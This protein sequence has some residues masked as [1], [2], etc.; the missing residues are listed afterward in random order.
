MA[1]HRRK[2]RGDSYTDGR[3]DETAKHEGGQ[4]R[5]TKRTADTGTE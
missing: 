4:M 2:D 5:Q 3:T 1:I